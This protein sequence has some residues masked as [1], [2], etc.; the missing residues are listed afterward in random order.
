MEFKIFARKFVWMGYVNVFQLSESRIIADTQITRIF[1]GTLPSH[2]WMNRGNSRKRPNKTPFFCRSE[3]RSRL[4]PK[5]MD[6]RIESGNRLNLFLVLYSCSGKVC[7]PNKLGHPEV[8]YWKTECPIY[9]MGGFVK[10]HRCRTRYSL[11]LNSEFRN[12]GKLG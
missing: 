6:A 1:Y 12:S 3:L 5:I 8:H 11:L 10:A 4:P 7:Y 2:L 9:S